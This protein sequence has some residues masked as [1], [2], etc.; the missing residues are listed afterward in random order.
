MSHE[1]NRLLNDL[2][3]ALR[4]LQLWQDERPSEEALASTQPFAIDTL[5]FHQWLQFILLERLNMM[6]AMGHPLPTS[7]SIYPMATE[8]YKEDLVA[9]SA[10]LEAIAR[11]DQ[12][13]SGKPV[14]RMQ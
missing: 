14:E 5:E 1:I 11:L 8:V 6:I 2:E 9:M 10:L 3:I 12:A 13:L 7:V 4:A